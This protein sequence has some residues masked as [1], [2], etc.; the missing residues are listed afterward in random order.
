MSNGHDKKKV[1]HFPRPEAP[2]LL[3]LSEIYFNP[4]W[5]A[6]DA[7]RYIGNGASGTKDGPDASALDLAE[8]MAA[9]GQKTPID[10]RPNPWKSKE[11]PQPYAAV[12]GFRRGSAI[13]TAHALLESENSR[14]DPKDPDRRHPR[15]SVEAGQVIAFVHEKMDEEEAIILNAIENL[16]RLDLVSADIAF[17][18][19][20]IADALGNKITHTE[21]GHMIGRSQP[22]IS[23][24]INI[25]NKVLP[26]I[27][28]AWRQGG[29]PRHELNPGGVAISIEN[30]SQVAA[31]PSEQQAELFK[32]LCSMGGKK[33]GPGRGN[34]LDSAKKTSAEIGAL[35]GT[36]HRLHYIDAN[37]M[38]WSGA[39]FGEKPGEAPPS[40]IKWHKDVN[41]QSETG[42]LTEKAVELRAILA[43]AAIDAYR[44]AVVVKTDEEIKAG[45]AAD[46]TALLRMSN[47]LNYK[48]VAID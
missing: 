40:K 9:E 25:K 38:E 35:I 24:L 11:H 47:Q 45:L 20:R 14:K 34:W 18:V 21:I 39:L 37:N 43:T 2:L 1:P 26:E 5:N 3:P 41:S 31:V 42:G 6:R 15:N 28:K 7:S 33:A 29:E 10:V 17:N 23:T 44:N 13:A 16:G 22:V 48:D 32:K 19:W 27:R 8:G 30:M 12:T 46:Q 4:D 36:L